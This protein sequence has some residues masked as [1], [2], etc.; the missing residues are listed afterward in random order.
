MSVLLLGG[1]VVPEDLEGP[2]GLLDLPSSL[3]VG[4]GDVSVHRDQSQVGPHS[5]LSSPVGPL[6]QVGG[7]RTRPE[8]GEGGVAAR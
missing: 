2:Q 4:L 7:P 3:A 8:R 1:L 5:R 6:T